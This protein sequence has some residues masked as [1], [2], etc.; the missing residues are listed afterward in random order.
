LPL[1]SLSRHVPFAIAYIIALM[2]TIHIPIN[3]RPRP[4]KTLTTR[5]T[6]A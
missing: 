5:P 2:L 6:F 3:S 1:P 4:V